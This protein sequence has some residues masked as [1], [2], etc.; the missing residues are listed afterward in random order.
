MEYVNNKAAAAAKH[1]V[2]VVQPRLAERSQS[3]DVLVARALAVLVGVCKIK[4]L[5]FYITYV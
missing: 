4:I 5:F 1:V 3:Q 2:V